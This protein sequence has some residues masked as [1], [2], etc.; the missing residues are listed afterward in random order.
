MRY[1]V[2]IVGGGSTW[3]PGLLKALVSYKE[4][5][6]IK[7]LTLFDINGERQYPIGEFAKILFKEEWSDVEV[8]HTT[9]KKE[10]YEN[11]D[12]IFC[13]MRTGGYKMREMDEKIPLSEGVLGQ[14]TCGAG[15]F[16]YGI[17]SLKDM[18]EMVEDIRKYSKDAW[19]L[20]YTNPAAIVAYGLTKK[21]P[22]DKRILNICDQPI[23]MLY[24]MAKILKYNPEDIIPKYF[25]LN[26]FGWFTNL[27]NKEGEDLL[28]QLKDLIKE[29]GFLPVDAEQRDK[30]WLD[31]YALVQD[32]VKDYDEYIPST[33]VQYYLYPEYKTSKLDPNY[34]RANEVM[35][36]REKKVFE[37]C[38]RVVADG[39][40]KGADVVKNDAHGE[41]IVAIAE[42]IA[43]N[44]NKHYIVMV[45][46]NGII[47]NLPKDAIVEVPC[48]LGN[49]GPI[50][51]HV[52]PIGTFYKGLLESQY[53]YEK[54]TVE[55][56]LEG[57][58]GKALQALTLNRTIVDGKKARKVL[59]KLM[60]A[61]KEYWPKMK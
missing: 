42:A 1:N 11:V 35:N 51:F 37:E 31:T 8:T 5:F 49:L 55:A 45:E 40:A 19:I 61:N 27:Y 33:Y 20:N 29:R 43:N 57:S 15:G 50:P 10:A 38:R 59:D 60:E 47:E 2:T 48:L 21:F 53:A 56:F 12:F 32:M 28:P 23:N 30:S 13:Q 9:D 16:A 25:G 17:R 46:N 44:K 39:T 7:K 22:N 24:S 3:T 26:H 36:G 54:L 4:K 6:Q 34:T 41:M 58:Y 18:I 14:E 52:G